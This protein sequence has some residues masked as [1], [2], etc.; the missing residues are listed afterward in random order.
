MATEDM[1]RMLAESRK[2]WRFFLPFPELEDEVKKTLAAANAVLMEKYGGGD[3]PPAILLDVLYPWQKEVLDRI[4]GNEDCAASVPDAARN[5]RFGDYDGRRFMEGRFLDLYC[6]GPIT[7]Q[8][9]REHGSRGPIFFDCVSTIYQ[10]AMIVGL[11]PLGW[12]FRDIR[13]V[14][15]K[16]QKALLS[17]AEA[18]SGLEEAALLLDQ[19]ADFLKACAEKA[20]NCGHAE[21]KP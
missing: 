12:A 7:A 3:P 21:G 16:P 5:V 19:G 15:E 2:E 13:E 10:E 9:M 18:V 20:A 1:A 11:G 8:S 4:A 14:A 6:V 17:L